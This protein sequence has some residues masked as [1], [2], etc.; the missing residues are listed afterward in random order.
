VEKREREKRE[1]RVMPAEGMVLKRNTH[2]TRTNKYRKKNCE[3]H[4]FFQ[5]MRVHLGSFEKSPEK[6]KTQL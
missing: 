3:E 2:F 6:R 1:W 4:F 5:L